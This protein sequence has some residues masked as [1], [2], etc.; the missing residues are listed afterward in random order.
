[1]VAQ[2]YECTKWHL[3]IHFKMFDFMLCEFQLNFKECRGLSLKV[4]LSAT[5]TKISIHMFLSLFL[6]VKPE[7]PVLQNTVFYLTVKQ[8]VHF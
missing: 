2:H 4:R 3:S 6:K 7:T 1:M 5:Q 8:M